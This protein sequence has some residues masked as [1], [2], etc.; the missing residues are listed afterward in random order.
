MA[1][2]YG[3]R[4]GTGATGFLFDANFAGSNTTVGQSDSIAFYNNVASITRADTGATRMWLLFGE[5]AAG[6]LAIQS[7]NNAYY[8]VNSP[9]GIPF[10]QVP[11][12]WPGGTAGVFVI[13]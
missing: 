4:E 1:P 11:S 3:S 13:L 7:N 8:Y 9:V 10:A 2:R 6:N 5:A 12:P